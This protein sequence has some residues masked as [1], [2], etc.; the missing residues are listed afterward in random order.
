MR[1]VHRVAGSQRVR[2]TIDGAI[3]S[4][5]STHSGRPGR[6]V[7]RQTSAKPTVTV[8][9]PTGPGLSTRGTIAHLSRSSVIASNDCTLMREKKIARDNEKPHCHAIVT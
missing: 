9:A 3:R 4:A 8:I 6:W 2:L 5:V 1:A 7:R